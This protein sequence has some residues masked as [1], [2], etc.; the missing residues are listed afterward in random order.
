MHV[1]TF[2]DK[3][4]IQYRNVSHQTPRDGTGYVRLAKTT[5]AAW[6]P[7][8]RTSMMLVIKKR[9]VTPV[10]TAKVYMES[11]GVAPLILNLDT[12]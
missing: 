12:S 7:N 10:H 3:T 1:S 11:R 2:E 6:K 9:Y 4:A 5:A 8:I